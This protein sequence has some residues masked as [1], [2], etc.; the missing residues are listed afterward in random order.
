[1]F[2]VGCLV[3][4]IFCTPCL[5]YST[6]AGWPT[7]PTLHTPTA[8]SVHP[9]YYIQHG[10]GGPRYQRYTLQQHCLYTLPIV[11]NTGRVAHDTNAT[12]SNSIV[13]ETTNDVFRKVDFTA[14][15]W[16]RAVALYV[17]G[18]PWSHLVR[19]SYEKY[20]QFLTQKIVKI[21]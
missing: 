2:S 12:H 15:S 3:H 18:I 1:M 6:R 16:R 21:Y 5:L 14:Q 19:Y 7:I 10:Q 8:L 17:Y 13:N 20:S 11:F 4:L 9:S